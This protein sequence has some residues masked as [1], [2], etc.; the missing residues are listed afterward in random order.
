MDAVFDLIR[1]CSIAM[2][3]AYGLRF[4]TLLGKTLSIWIGLICTLLWNTLRALK[5]PTYG[6]HFSL[7]L[8]KTLSLLIRSPFSN[9]IMKQ[10]NSMVTVFP[11]S[12]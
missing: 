8:G 5:Y 9:P 12:F 7:L 11:K 2:V 10:T 3:H 1:D 4:L 6:D